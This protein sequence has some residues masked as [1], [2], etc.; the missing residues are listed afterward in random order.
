MEQ[1]KELFG[2][3]P[4]T[5]TAD[6]GYYDGAIIEKLGDKV[7]NIAIAKKGKRTTERVKHEHSEEF[8][9]AQRFRAGIEG[10]ISFLKRVLGLFRCFSKGWEHFVSTV[11]MTVVTHNLLKLAVP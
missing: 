3:Y 5:L 11:G 10:S 9:S 8:R 4:E 7:D 1:H 2:H 6:K